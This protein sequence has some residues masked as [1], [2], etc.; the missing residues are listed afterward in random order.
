MLD[1]PHWKEFIYL[2][3]VSG[4][5]QAFSDASI[6]LRSA[7]W[8]VTLFL[9]VISMCWLVFSYPISSWQFARTLIGQ[10]AWREL[11]QHEQCHYRDTQFLLFRLFKPS[12]TTSGSLSVYRTKQ[13]AY[14]P[15]N[16]RSSEICC[17]YTWPTNRIWRDAMHGC[18]STAFASQ[19]SIFLFSGSKAVS[20]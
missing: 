12:L 8:G 13:I 2:L 16:A 9:K 20:C 14:S 6:Y 10:K 3:N 7:L 18:D 1:L 5:C 15:T 11:G 4:L 19:R 17:R